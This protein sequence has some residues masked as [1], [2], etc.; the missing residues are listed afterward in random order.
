M[1]RCARDV[2]GCSCEGEWERPEPEEGLREVRSK[3]FNHSE[4]KW[5][6]R[7]AGGGK[8][9][10]VQ[11]YNNF[12]KAMG[13]LE[14]ELSLRRLPCVPGKEPVLLSP[15]LT[16]IDQNTCLGRTQQWVSEHSTWGHRSVMVSVVGN[17][18][19]LFMATGIAKW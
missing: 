6:R 1:V 5:E 12:G 2:L 10:V 13:L 14:S 18:R 11:F 4:E 9:P 8:Q 16:A 3:W 19:G 15:L 17:L 7:K